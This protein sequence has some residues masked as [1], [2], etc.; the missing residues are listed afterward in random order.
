LGQ[1]KKRAQTQ[2]KRPTATSMWKVKLVVN[3]S[4]VKIPVAAPAK[5]EK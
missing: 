5:K 3:E 2:L 4:E 1:K